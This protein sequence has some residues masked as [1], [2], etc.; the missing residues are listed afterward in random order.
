MRIPSAEPSGLAAFS[1]QWASIC[2]QMRGWPDEVGSASICE[3]KC[4]GCGPLLRRLRIKCGFLLAFR[5]FGQV[6]ATA[7]TTPDLAS[8]GHP[9]HLREQMRDQLRG[10]GLRRASCG[11][12]ICILAER[13]SLGGWPNELHRAT[14]RT[15]L[16]E[17]LAERTHSRNRE[18]R[19]HSRAPTGIGRKNDSRRERSPRR[20][21]PLPY[22]GVLGAGRAGSFSTG[23]RF[24]IAGGVRQVEATRVR[25][26]SDRWMRVSVPTRSMA[27][28]EP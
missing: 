3:S 13:T 18:H 17:G 5:K 9:E 26:L 25:G 15:K 2:L 16:E 27:S 11:M 21:G 10:E 23:S 12:R 28:I 24:G 7:R 22:P 19:C 14:G 8:R 20:P 6:A 1:T 4:G